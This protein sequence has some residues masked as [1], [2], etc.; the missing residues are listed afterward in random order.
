M[1][2]TVTKSLVLGALFALSTTAAAATSNQLPRFL[3]V[4]ALGLRLPLDRLNLDPFPED[5]RATCD[6]ISDKER[7]TGRMWIFGRAKDAAST[8]FVLSGYFKRRSPDAE[9]RLYEFFDD[10]FVLTIRGNNCGG[11]P[12]ASETF[13]ARDPNADNTGN[14][15]IPIL[16]ELARDLAAQTV[17]A[18]GGADQLRAEIKNQRLDFNTLS[19]ELQEAFRPYFSAALKQAK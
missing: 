7:S 13:D 12:D 6:Q 19:P 17:R 15:P 3:T 9:Q 16:R 10:G 4:P 2:S 14:V 1:S 8:Y 18:V 11:D 5:I